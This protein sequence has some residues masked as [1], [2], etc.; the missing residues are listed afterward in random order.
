MK[1]SKARI[2][3]I[4]NDISEGDCTANA[5]ELIQVVLFFRKQADEWIADAHSH[6]TALLLFALKQNQKPFP[7][8]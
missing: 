4:S 3:Q 7:N 5:K 2:L 8:F 1:L 6:R